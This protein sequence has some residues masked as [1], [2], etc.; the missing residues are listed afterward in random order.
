MT[1][2][3]ETSCGMRD[4]RTHSMQS[5]SR[6]TR[7]KR[8]KTG[9]WGLTFRIYSRVKANLLCICKMALQLTC[10]REEASLQGETT[11][12]LEPVSRKSRET[13]GV[14]IPVVSQEWRGCKSSNLYKWLFEPANVSGLSKISS[15][16]PLER[17]ILKRNFEV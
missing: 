9:H 17:K 5:Y 14:T 2:W 1:G 16:R 10:K 12:M 11:T 4:S 13:S 8:R 3:N 7:K 6:V 15:V